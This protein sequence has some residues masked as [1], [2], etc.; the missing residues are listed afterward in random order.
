MMKKFGKTNVLAFLAVMFFGLLASCSQGN[1]NNP[2]KWAQDAIAM[3]EDSVEKV[4]NE[5]VGK[6][7]YI[8]NCRQFARK[9]IDDKISDTYKEM[10]EKV[11]DKSDEEKWELFK[12]FRADIDSAFSKMDQHYDQVSQ[13]EEK[14]L[15]GKSLKVASDTQSFDNTKTKAEIVDFS[16][17]S[18]VKIKVTLTPTKPLG[19][20]F[21][22]IL[23]DKDQKPI[24]PFALMTMPKKAGETLT[25][26]TNV[27]IALLAQTSM[28]LFDAR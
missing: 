8:D 23:V 14:K 19:N 10:E 27:P 18:K 7:L 17:R 15:I 16:H 21:R 22:M 20:S 28:L 24:A 1:D 2:D 5:M 12:G 13:E 3:A 4:D 26:E 9:A 11:K 6:L 25:V